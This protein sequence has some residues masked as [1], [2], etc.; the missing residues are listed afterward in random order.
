MMWVGAHA[1]VKSEGC[2]VHARMHGDPIV[3]Y[4]T[5]GEAVSPAQLNGSTIIGP[6]KPVGRTK[7]DNDARSRDSEG[8]K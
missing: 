1:L 7:E 6:C 3:Q 8:G 5:G 2:S 4:W